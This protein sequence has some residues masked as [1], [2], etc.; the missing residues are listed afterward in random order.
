MMRTRLGKAV[1]EWSLRDGDVIAG[2][3]GVEI[4]GVRLM[5]TAFP[6]T[7]IFQGPE[8]WD[9]RAFR[10]MKTTTDGDTVVIHTSAIGSV[11]DASWY[12]DQYDHDILYL[13]RPREVPAL[14]VDFILAPTH[15]IYNGIAFDGFSVAWRI[16][17]KSAKLGRLRW[18]QHWEIDGRAEGNTVYWQSQ[19]AS[20]V[21][22]FT[23][24]SAW[25]NFC[26]KTLLKDKVDEN[27][28]MQVNC[29]AAYHQLFDMLASPAGVFL[30]YFPEAQSVQTACRKNAGEDQYHV[31]ESLEFPLASERDIAGKTLLFARQ[32]CPTEASR[33]NLWFDVN[34]TLENSY[35]GQTGIRRSR[36]LPTLTHWMWGAF[37]EGDQLFYDPRKT[38]ERVP[39]ERYLEWLGIHEMPVAREKGFRR[40][41]TRPY[42]VSDASEEMFRTK[43][44]QGASVMDGD[45]TI[46]SC[47]CVREYKPSVMYG[48]GAMARR[49][50]ELGHENGLEV[51]IWVGNHLSTKAPMLRKHP[52]WVLKDRNFAN[53]A[54]GYDDQIMAVVNWNSG[55]REWILGDLLAWKKNYGLDFVFFD[56]LGNLGLKTRN[57][58]VPDLADNFQGLVRF[59]ADLTGAGVEVICEGRSFVGAP[60]FGIS[61]DGNMESASD[62]LRGQNSLGWFLDNEDMFCGMEAFTDHNPRVP[63]DRIIA[64][65]FRTMAGG[66]LLDIGGGPA[67]LDANFHIYNQVR[68]FMKRRTVLEDGRGVLWEAPDGTQVLFAF[69]DGRWELP[70]PARVRQ[71][72]AEGLNDLGLYQVIE[73]K[74]RTVFLVTPES[75]R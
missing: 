59:V 6:S 37:A 32:A 75:R 46:G 34:E 9:Y 57:Y 41:W 58:A 71:V 43:A 2:L 14:E 23:R 12:R 27:I 56:S 22:T 38:G 19:I 55:A 47:C 74:V 70:A 68:E 26:W 36:V 31:S 20:P 17:C 30:G 44:M 48:G 3:G 5:D 28:S 13:G 40:F 52:D 67:E 65:H 29:R 25:D 24:D 63:E 11:A 73:P 66:G 15:A 61:N 49:F 33:R 16:R 35:R 45:V 62:P 54:G 51:G 21:A 64:M 60:H 53:P 8:G 4:D 39:A 72:T 10:H 18:H 42:C 69:K 1:L 7:F 50:Y